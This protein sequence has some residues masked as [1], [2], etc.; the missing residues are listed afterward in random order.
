MKRLEQIKANILSWEDLAQRVNDWKAAGEKVVFTNGCFDLIH[1]GHLS[2]LAEARSL[3]DRLVIGVNA[4]ASV[5][6]LKGA[7][8]PI[9]DQNTRQ[10][11]LAS[12]SFVDAVCLFEE[13]TPF[14]LI[15]TVIPDILVKGGDWTPD[16]IVGSDVVL[17]NGGKVLSLPYIDGHSTTSLEAKIKK[18]EKE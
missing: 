11:L 8:R 2:Y 12:L 1:Y 6:R 13:D 14:D 4:D 9:K 3:G 16:K 15:K 5:R 17:A 10:L 18:Q 7:H